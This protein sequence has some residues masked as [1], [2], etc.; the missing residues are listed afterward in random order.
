MK[1]IHYILSM[2][3][4]QFG[5]AFIFTVF[6]Y[7]SGTLQSIVNGEFKSSVMRTGIFH[8]LA[9]WMVLILAALFDWAMEYVDLGGVSD[10]PISGCVCAFIAIMEIGSILE[11]L[12]KANDDIPGG[13]ADLLDLAR[14]RKDG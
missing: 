4:N 6:D 7:A 9:L 1:F 5:I 3:S 11:N 2:F 10:L 14:E 12:H 8:K 13:V